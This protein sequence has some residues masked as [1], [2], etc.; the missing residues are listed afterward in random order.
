MLGYTLTPE[1]LQLKEA[2]K[3]WFHANTGNHLH[4]GISYNGKWQG[5]M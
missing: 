3:D 1:D 5:W 2:Y 4:R